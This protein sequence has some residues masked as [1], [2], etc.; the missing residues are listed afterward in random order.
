MTEGGR[1]RQ[2]RRVFRDDRQGVRVND[3]VFDELT[4]RTVEGC[5][6]E[7]LCESKESVSVSLAPVL[8]P[9]E[10]EDASLARPL[11]FFPHSD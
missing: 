8:A 9:P 11:A 2:G 5:V 10:D 3:G 4:E 1:A 6:N 7:R